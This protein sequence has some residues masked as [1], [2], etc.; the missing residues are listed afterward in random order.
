MAPALKWSLMGIGALVVVVA[1]TV[2]GFLVY[3]NRTFLSV[4][5]VLADSDAATVEALDGWVRSLHDDRKFNGVLSVRVD[6]DV[7]YRRAI[8]HW[9]AAG[10][11]AL[12]PSTPLRLASLSKPYTATAVL[13]LVDAGELD[14]DAPVSLYLPGCDFGGV[15]LR[16]LL[17]HSSGVPDRYMELSDRNTVVTTADAAAHICAGDLVETPGLTYRYNNSGYVL[18][19]RVLETVTGGTFEAAMERIV[20]APLGLSET[21]VW[22]LMSGDGG[23]QVA[24]TFLQWDDPPSAEEPGILD[25]VAGDGGV[26]SSLND[27]ES[28]ARAWSDGSVLSP[29]LYIQARGRG[30]GQ[31]GLGW[32]VQDNGTI[33]HNGSWLGARTMMAINPDRQSWIIIADNGGSLATDAIAAEI[34]RWARHY[35]DTSDSTAIPGDD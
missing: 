23:L 32:V 25:G 24:P 30:V 5:P 27:L 1:A 3:L 29:G 19:A 10:D 4:P 31:H 16:N 21:R 18:M 8:G 15:A 13:R 14:L 34:R 11:R 17:D 7:V 35:Q 6:G 20:F 2:I 12:T 33:W 26:H 28:F 9:S 22:N